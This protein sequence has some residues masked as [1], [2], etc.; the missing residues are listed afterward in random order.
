MKFFITDNLY[1]QIASIR[2]VRLLSFGAAQMGL[3]Y[4]ITISICQHNSLLLIFVPQIAHYL[5][6][7]KH[8][9]SHQKSFSNRRVKKPVSYVSDADYLQT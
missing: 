6:F 2:M 1:S 9:L 3:R 4:S 7:T 5:D 8:E